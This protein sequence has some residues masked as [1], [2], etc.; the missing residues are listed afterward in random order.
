MSIDKYPYRAKFAAFAR[1]TPQPAQE[2]SVAVAA[3]SNI[4]QLYTEEDY[5]RIADNP[6]LMFWSSNLALLD[7]ANLNGDALRKET[8]LK[9]L[10]MFKLKLLDVEHNRSEIV[11]AIYKAGFSVYGT[12]QVISAEEAAKASYPVQLVV[13]GYIWRVVA[14]DLCDIIEECSIESSPNYGDVSTSFEIAFDDY[15]IGLGPDGERNIN[16]SMVIKKDHADFAKFDKML[17]SKGGK[18]VTDTGMLVYRILGGD[19]LPLGAGVVAKPASGL[20]GMVV[21]EVD[22]APAPEAV[23]T[24]EEQ[25]A[26]KEGKTLNK[27]FRLPAGSNKKFGVYVKNEKGNVVVVKFG[28][29]NMEIKRDDPERRKNFRARHQCDTNPGPKWKARYW[30]CRMWEGG[31][32]VTDYIEGQFEQEFPEQQ[33]LLDIYPDL[34]NAEVIEDSDDCCMEP[35]QGYA[36]TEELSI[37]N[38][39]NS[40]KPTINTLTPMKIKSIDELAQ[41]WA[42]IKTLETAAS[43]VTDLMEVTEASVRDQ[44]ANAIA[45]KSEEFASQLKEKE[46]LLTAAKEAAE[47]QAGKAKEFE[48]MLATLKAELDAIKAAQAA[49]AQEAKF[50]S[51]MES[52]EAEFDLDDEDRSLIVEEVRCM[53]DDEMFAKWMGKQKKLMA[54]K[55][56]SAVASATPAPV[57]APAAPAVPVAEVIAS[58]T[59]LPNQA[60]PNAP[61]QTESLAAKVRSVMSETV[62]VGKVKISDLKQK[63]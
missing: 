14:G 28:D 61:T 52:I 42:E 41:K 43:I 56:K 22:K 55:K 18:G 9:V 37:K 40:V 54:G 10:E 30:S 21:V 1:A 62:T 32:S 25:I 60:I 39:L 3:L 5:K 44:I 11:G 6:D 58:V 34:A 50:N 4:K 16:E 19:V 29:P 35:E 23:P 45:A 59:E 48:G 36:T 13:G 27:P 12:N 47:A 7:Y 53:V 31:K 46:E 8:A 2:K 63:A 24:A 38:Q 51:R 49:A 26:A 15:E 33:E 20:K 17:K 57:A